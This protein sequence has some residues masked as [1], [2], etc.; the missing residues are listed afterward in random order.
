MATVMTNLK[1][2]G[3]G[4]LERLNK[5]VIQTITH[6]YVD[7]R[8]GTNTGDVWTIAPTSKPEADFIAIA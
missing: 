3:N 1:S 5:Y 2:N 4:K 7:G 8:V 6:R